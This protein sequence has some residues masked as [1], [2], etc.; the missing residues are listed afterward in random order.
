MSFCKNNPQNICFSH[1]YRL[2]LWGKLKIKTMKLH[3]I[4]GAVGQ[5]IDEEKT[6][7]CCDKFKDAPIYKPIYDGDM[8]L[9]GKPD[10]IFSWDKYRFEKVTQSMMFGNGGFGDRFWGDKRLDKCPFCGA[11]LKRIRFYV[12]G[13]RISAKELKKVKP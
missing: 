8:Y 13:E 1:F 5:S 4:R 9:G 10:Y 2:H 3:I 11:S 7:W 6:R 12:N